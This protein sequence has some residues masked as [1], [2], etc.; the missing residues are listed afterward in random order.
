[1]EIPAKH[2]NLFKVFVVVF[3]ISSLINIFKA[4]YTFGKYLFEIGF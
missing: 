3:T 1:M 2:Q 4:G